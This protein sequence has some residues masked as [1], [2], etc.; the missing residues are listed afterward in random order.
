MTPWDGVDQASPGQLN[1]KKETGGLADELL[2]PLRNILPL[3]LSPGDDQHR[4]VTRDG[5]DDFGPTGLIQGLGDRAGEPS[6]VFR[7]RNGPTP[8]TLTSRVGRTCANSGRTAP[9]WGWV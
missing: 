5:A 6:A 2:N 1:C 9:R 3:A 8:S 7:T 4:V